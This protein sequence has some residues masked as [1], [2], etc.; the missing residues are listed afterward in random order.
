MLVRYNA[1][2]SQLIKVVELASKHNV[3]IE[4]K[5]EVIKHLRQVSDLFDYYNNFLIEDKN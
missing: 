2:L 4:Y 5:T 3:R 1:D